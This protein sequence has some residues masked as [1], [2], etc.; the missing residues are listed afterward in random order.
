MEAVTRI[1][2]PASTVV[3]F[4]VTART[5]GIGDAPVGE[6]GDVGVPALPPQC[7]AAITVIT[8]VAARVWFRT[9]PPASH[10]AIGVPGENSPAQPR[11]SFH[12]RRLHNRGYAPG[13]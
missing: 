3:R 13:V 12:H 5:T 4:T 11:N 6:V 9:V 10:G 8:N 2:S 7:D 1:S